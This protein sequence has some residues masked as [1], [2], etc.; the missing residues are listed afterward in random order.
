M[1]RYFFS[2]A[3]C[4]AH[5]G[6]LAISGNQALE[7]MTGSDR[8]DLLLSTYVAA[9]FDQEIVVR[10][11][12]KA[13]IQKG[14][15]VPVWP[16]CPPPAASAQQGASVIRNALRNDPANNHEDLLLIARRAFSNAWECT[17]AQVLK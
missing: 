16:F 15:D 1:I 13:M 17:P 14:G 5:S 4:L 2:C 3:V 9:L 6:A 11:N 10:M 7:L 12:A 8:K